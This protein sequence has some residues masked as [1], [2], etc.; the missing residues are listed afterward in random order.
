MFVNGDDITATFFLSERSVMSALTVSSGGVPAGTYLA[1]FVG[2]E[3]TQADAQRGYG[4]GLRWKFRVDAGPQVGQTASRVTGTTPSTKNGCGK[5]LFGVAGR[6]LR[7]GESVDPAE[8]INRK[9]TIVVATGP[10]GGSRV[11]AIVPAA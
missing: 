4:P 8:F 7:E 9:Y 2:T 3:P 10:Q 6:Q 11:E 1:T 5:M